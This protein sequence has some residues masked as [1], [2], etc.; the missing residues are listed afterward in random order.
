MLSR[1]RCPPLMPL[2]K[3]REDDAAIVYSQVREHTMSKQSGNSWSDTPWMRMSWVCTGTLVHPPA[4]SQEMV[5]K[6]SD[7]IRSDIYVG[8]RYGISIS[9][10]GHE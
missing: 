7:M 2:F 6:H 1:R 5:P 10:I 8:D 4:Y 9:V 3:I